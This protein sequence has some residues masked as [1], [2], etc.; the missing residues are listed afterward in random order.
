MVAVAAVLS[1]LIVTSDLALVLDESETRFRIVPVVKASAE[2][3]ITLA[4]V[5]ESA[6]MS[7]RSKELVSK[8]CSC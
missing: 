4:V 7:K 6:V 8:L 1:F 2:I 3:S 5:R